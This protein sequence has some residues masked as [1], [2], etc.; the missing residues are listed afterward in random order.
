[1]Q[2]SSSLW[3]AHPDA[4]KST[5]KFYSDRTDAII[6]IIGN[7]PVERICATD[8]RRSLTECPERSSP[9]NYRFLKRL[10]NFLINEE[11]IKANPMAKLKPP[12]IEQ[13]VIEPLNQ[14][15]LQKL[16]RV[17]RTAE[18]SWGFGT[19]PY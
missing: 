10:F 1:M 18:A 6:R 16:F 5:Q 12:K 9:L 19:R 11:V 8:L 7:K 4:S 2:A 14:E 13:K 3:R 15:Q 17:A